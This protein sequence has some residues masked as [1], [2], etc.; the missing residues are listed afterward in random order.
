MKIFCYSSPQA[1][2]LSLFLLL[3][4]KRGTYPKS[5]FH[6][7]RTQYPSPPQPKCIRHDVRQD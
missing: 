1:V 2:E 4:A 7:P 5:T 6:H 3:G